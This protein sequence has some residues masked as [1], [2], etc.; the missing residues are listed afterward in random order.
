[1]LQVRRRGKIQVFVIWLWEKLVFLSLGNSRQGT[2]RDRDE[3]VER[4]GGGGVS[5]VGCFLRVNR[6]VRT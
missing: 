4:G 1:M 6:G 3:K 5:G 2:G